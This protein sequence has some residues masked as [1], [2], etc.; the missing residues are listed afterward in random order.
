MYSAQRSIIFGTQNSVLGVS[1]KGLA[2]QLTNQGGLIETYLEHAEQQKFIEIRA[3]GS[4]L[5]LRRGY[6]G[7]PCLVYQA[8]FELASTCQQNAT[9]IAE[10]LRGKNYVEVKKPTLPIIEGSVAAELFT[11]A[12]STHPV[13][14]RWLAMNYATEERA[15]QRLRL[16]HFPNG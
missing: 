13:H 11:D 4:T 9:R 2:M 15:T 1:G 10:S 12:L 14:R 16:L 8:T 5:R 7:R 3:D 6:I